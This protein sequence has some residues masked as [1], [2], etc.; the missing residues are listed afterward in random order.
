MNRMRRQME[1]QKKVVNVFFYELSLIIYQPVSSKYTLGYNIDYLHYIKIDYWIKYRLFA[2][3]N[4]LIFEDGKTFL[5][6]HFFIFP[7]FPVLIL[8][9]DEEIF[10]SFFSSKIFIQ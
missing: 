8:I 6:L 5:L 7:L 9:I 3:L 10:P 1:E 4:V 2:A